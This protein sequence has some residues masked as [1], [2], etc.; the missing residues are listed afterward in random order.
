MFDQ[1]TKYGILGL[2]KSGIAA[3]YK[4]K[5]L[6]G[7]AFLSDVSTMDKINGSNTLKCDFECEFG[8]HT[9]RLLA[10]DTWIVSPGIPL[11]IPI[12]DKGREAGIKIISEIE[13][14]YQI[15]SPDSKVIAITGSNGK[16]T[17]SSLIYHILSRLGYRSLL[18]GNIGDAV[19]GFPIEEAGYQIL[20][21]EV[22][23]FQLDLID[24]FH[25]DVSVLLN[26]TP[27][28]LN[29]YRSFSHYAA[30]KFR[31]FENQNEN[32][33]AILNRNDDVIMSGLE[34]IRSRKMFFS[35]H[36]Y[37]NHGVD[38]WMNDVF[39]HIY[40]TYQLSKYNLGIRGP[41]NY[42]NAMAALLA[43]DVMVNRMEEALQAITSF[44]PLN[45]RLEMVRT[46]NGIT[47]YNDSKATNTDS[48]KNALLSFDKPIRIIMGGSDKGEDF[49]VLTD[50][51]TTKA[52]KVYITGATLDRM[53][54]TWLGKVPLLCEESFE[55]CVRHA[56]EDSDIGDN[57][58]LSPACASFDH[59]RNFEHRG[60]VY[61]QIVNQIA[62][63]YEKN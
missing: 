63:E 23:S 53:R 39:I 48:V 11:D 18:A 2:A 1:K 52:I 56:F 13:F 9:D 49:S 10:C 21:L 51:L 45:H 29:R 4:I 58:V 62:E 38:A 33:Y 30:S 12:I 15:K 24:T 22:S 20:V 60:E 25:P 54:Q 7:Q 61:K 50:I 32:D 36:R 47:F 6:G 42:S 17:T 34:R 46:I 41:H 44:R 43:V 14:A 35:S 57:I 31:I 59:F 26:I 40:D 3:A 55:R 8:E 37:D 28:H 16:S 5:A 27:D 19:S